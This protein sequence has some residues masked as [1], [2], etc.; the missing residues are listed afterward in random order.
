MRVLRFGVERFGFLRQLVSP[1]LPEQGIVAIWGLNEAGK[2]SLLRFFRQIFFGFQRDALPLDGSRPAGWVEVSS[3]SG[4]RVRWER[5]GDSRRRREEARLLLIEGSGRTGAAKGHDGASEVTPA[6]LLGRIK[7]KVYS[8]VF[9][10]GLDELERLETLKEIELGATLYTAAGLGAL[11]LKLPDVEETLTGELERLIAPR[12]TSARINALIG[13]LRQVAGLQRELRQE[14]GEWRRGREKEGELAARLAELQAEEERIRAAIVQVERRIQAWPHWQGLLQAQQEMAEC[15][16]W[17]GFPADGVARLDAMERELAELQEEW[18]RKARTRQEL[19]EKL[20]AIRVDEEILRAAEGWE[21]LRQEQGRWQGL[22]EEKA[23]L[24]LD[25][26]SATRQAAEEMARLGPGWSEERVRG[27]EISL[28]VEEELEIIRSASERLEEQIREAKRQLRLF[29]TEGEDAVQADPEGQGSSPGRAETVDAAAGVTTGVGVEKGAAGEPGEEDAEGRLEARYT[30]LRQARHAWKAARAAA[31][32]LASARR[33]YEAWERE[34]RRSQALAKEWSEPGGKQGAAGRTVRSSSAG[35]IASTVVAGAL[36]AVALFFAGVTSMVGAIILGSALFLVLLTTILW[37]RKAG[38]RKEEELRRHLAATLAR[39]LVQL[40]AEGERLR[41]EVQSASACYGQLRAE[42]LRLLEQAGIAGG[43]GGAQESTDEAIEDWVESELEKTIAELH[44]VREAKQRRGQAYSA[45][46]LAEQEAAQVRRRWQALA[47]RTGLDA[48][49]SP[50]TAGRVLNQ[51]KAVQGALRKRDDARARLDQVEAELEGFV[52]RFQQAVV[53]S[54]PANESGVAGTEDACWEE[55]PRWL[56]RLESARQAAAE[57]DRLGALLDQAKEAEEEVK[58]RRDRMVE[59]RGKLLAAGGTDEPEVFRLRAE[60]VERHRR[61]A[62]R[63]REEALALGAA[64]GLTSLPGLSNAGE[65]EVGAGPLAAAGEWPASGID[66]AA[67]ASYARTEFAGVALADLVASKRELEERLQSVKQEREGVHGE[68]VALQQR[69]AALEVAANRVELRQREQDL[70]EELK[71]AVAEASII[72]IAR[73][74]LSECRR[75]YEAER[76]PAVLRRA[77]A[78]LESITCG[79]YRRVFLP[80]EQGPHGRTGDVPL[81]VERDDGQLRPPETLSRGTAEQLYLAL[82]L[83]LIEEYVER[84]GALPVLF[85][86]VFVNFDPVRLKGALTALHRLARELQVFLFTCHP[87]V[88]RAAVQSASDL[89]VLV[90]ENGHTL[91][92][93]APPEIEE[94]VARASRGGGFA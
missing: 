73:G 39:P 47:E 46:R 63:A 7:E 38:A 56:Q 14:T 48:S 10:F 6:D 19:E 21:R 34:E 32:E 41:A 18:E 62:Q 49:L 85:D 5:G 82:R 28:E 45:L 58:V 9:A 83:A 80:L 94:M 43:P 17:P 29:G 87:H 30:L 69:L 44:R 42:A 93:A 33:D 78:Y 52:R 71:Q 25:L 27:V 67:I 11:A 20:A 74:L 64:L 31:G 54:L 8:N 40:A 26:A 60:T 84:N 23:R 55:L 51:V 16:D 89:T 76:Q 90:L 77:G 22:R 75:R 13:E 53:A 12:R 61:A 66:M 1:E 35:V 24:Q 4:A 37:T 86:D 59:A 79:R 36:L 57:R 3:P 81:Q 68:L 91:V 88:V 70:R 72:A 50:A 92:P 2:S 65:E 15:P